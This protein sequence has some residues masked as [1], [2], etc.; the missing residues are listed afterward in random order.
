MIEETLKQYKETINIHLRKFI[1][2]RIKKVKGISPVA[3]EIM[4]HIME[5]NMRGGKRIRPILVIMGYRAAGGTKDDIIKAAIAVELMESFLLIHD[6]IIDQDELR[7]GYLTMHK[8]FE[9]KSRRCYSVDA[10]RYGESMA[11]IAGDILSVLGTEAIT[12]SDFPVKNKLRAI[13]RFNRAVINTCIGQAMDVKAGCDNNI[14]EKDIEQLNML[15]TAIYTFVAPL[16]IGALLAGANEKKLKILEDYGIPLGKAY[17]L[18]DDI[19]GLFGTKIKIGKPVASDIR[20][21][22]K[23]LLILRTLKKAKSADKKFINNCLGNPD[24]SSK[25]VSRI[26]QIAIDTGA[27]DYSE[28]SA[29]K[30]AA[31]SRAVIEKSQLRKNGKEFLMGLTEYVVKR[32]F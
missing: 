32:K 21:G 22:K 20:E 16:Q 5:F 1:S 13:E 26:R 30:L 28:T 8:V 17:Q 9:Q 7:R 10:C 19:L 27:K 11:L 29:K 14:T 6:D 18:Q 31:Q 12:M 15:K 23:T 2:D 4:E 25:D 24:I 3:S